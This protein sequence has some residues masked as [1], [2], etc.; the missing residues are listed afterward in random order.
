MHEATSHQELADNTELVQFRSIAAV[1]A[2]GSYARA[3]LGD[4][5]MAE[6]T[7]ILEEVQ[8]IT[9]VLPA[10]PGT[11]FRSTESLKRWLELHYFTLTQTLAS[12]EGHGQARLTITKTVGTDPDDVTS[13]ETKESAKLL[14]ATASQSMRVLRGHAAATITLPP[15]EGDTSV[16]TQASFLVELDSWAEFAD[17]VK[18][19]DER[20]TALDF[21][22]TG[23]W[24]PYDFVKMQFGG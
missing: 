9:A 11:V 15:L 10:P 6:Y 23:P 4:K 24:P 16:V 12:I 8:S 14:V 3:V 22:L 2:P 20:Q 18:K 7:A 1:V 5:E 19:E 13:S 17:L 21:E